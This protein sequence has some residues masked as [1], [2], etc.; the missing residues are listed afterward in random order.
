M[1]TGSGGLVGSESVRFF[2]DLGWRTIGLDNDMRR[3]FFGPSGS[4]AKTVERIQ[5][6]CP[7]YRHFN[8]DIRDRGGV[9]EIIHNERPDLII[10]TAAQPSHDKAASIPY[11]DFDVNAAGTLNLL[12]AARDFCP[13]SPFCFTS[14]NKVYGDLTDLALQ[15][16]GQQ[17]Q[18]T[19]LALRAFQ[20]A[21]GLP[22][23][24]TTDALT[25]Q[26]VL[27]LA[28]QPVSW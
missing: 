5:A 27:S 12:V 16:S 22:V 24:G 3:E 26:A 2:S 6:E 1:I 28:H 14:T 8:I 21:R 15:P 9:R 7:D 10:H 25:W 18:P 17:Y 19:D 13:E 4:T 11:D 23:T 20:Q